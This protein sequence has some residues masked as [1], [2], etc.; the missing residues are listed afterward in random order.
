MD[1]PP[2]QLSYVALLVAQNGVFSIQC[3]VTVSL[4]VPVLSCSQV[5]V[6]RK[7]VV[8]EDRPSPRQSTRLRERVFVQ[9]DHSRREK[10]PQKLPAVVGLM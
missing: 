3:Q 2:L 6:T 9:E 4:A 7:L 8:V 1:I 10:L 5:T